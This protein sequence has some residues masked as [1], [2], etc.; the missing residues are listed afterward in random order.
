[1]NQVI[2]R[3]EALV[4]SGQ[5]RPDPEQ[6]AAAERLTALQAALEASPPRGSVL[7]RLTG[8]KPEPVRG[9]YMWGG[10]GRGKSMLMDLF[11]GCLH[12][13]RK[14]RVAAPSGRGSASARLPGR[15]RLEP[16]T[17]HE[18][19]TPSQHGRSGRAFVR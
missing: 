8:R 7:W 17:G 6:R 4:A 19:G 5:L 14:R 16:G 12:I 18:P 10:V 3:Y 2:D 15:P 9:L 13:N 1:M 11:Y